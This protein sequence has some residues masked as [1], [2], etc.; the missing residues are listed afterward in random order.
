MSESWSFRWCQGDVF[1]KLI[2][3]FIKQDT[4]V[5][6]ITYSNSTVIYTT[7]NNNTATLLL[8]QSNTFFNSR[9][10]FILLKLLRYT[11]HKIDRKTTKNLK[12]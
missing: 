7:Y 10:T 5:A 1:F 2:C 12:K 4:T 11:T 3:N 9:I 6:Y 8:F